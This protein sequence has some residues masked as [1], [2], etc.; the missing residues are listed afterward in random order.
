VTGDEKN[1]D[2][3]NKF[4]QPSPTE[5]A[6][7]KAVF[8]DDFDD[9]NK[10][11]LDDELP[12]D[13]PLTPELVE[14][15]AI[16]GDFMLRWAAI[17]LAI[18]MA[19]GQISDTRP[20]VLIRSGDQMRSNGFLP[21]QVDQF[22]LTMDGK[23]VTN[24]SW[25]FDH[26]VS[27]SWML[28]GEAG[29]TIL[30][31]LIAGVSAFFLVRI[32]IPG[33]SSWWSSI[34]A[35]FA[36]V[37]CSSD[38]MPTPEL[39]TVLGIT[40][41][42]RLL[43]Q[44]RLGLA[45]GLIWKLPVLIALWC[46]F[47][48]RAWVGV[49]VIAS[50]AIGSAISGKLAARKQS[51]AAAAEHRTLLV[52]AILC[53]F[54]LLANPFHINSLLSPLTTYSTEY[55]ALRAQRHLDTE[56]AKVRFD[57]RVDYYSVLNPDA[58]TLFDHSQIAGLALLLMATVVLLMSRSARDLGF[59]FALLFVTGLSVL[60]AHELSAGAVVAAVIAS[61]SAQDWYR[62]SFNTKYTVDNKELLFSRGGRAATVLALALVGFCVVAS[63]LPGTLPLGLGFD[64][65]TKITIDT[66]SQQLKDLDPQAH[67]LH[68][69]IEQGDMLI[70]NGRKSFVDSRIIPFGRRGE[71]TSVFGKHGNFL[72][73]MLLQRP[74]EEPQVTSS[75][76]KE[77]ERILAERAA[78]L[79]A[80]RETVQE[81][82]VTHV[83]SR[84]APPGKA[85]FT[86][87]RNLSATGE[88]IPVSIGPSAAILER[89]AP[90]ISQAEFNKKMINLPKLAF[91]NTDVPPT[92]LRQ[93]ATAPGFYEKYVY[94]K[95]RVTTANKR[96]GSHY[97]ELSVKEPQ[98]IAQAQAA[99]A[100]LTLSIRH[101]NQSLAEMP[102]DAE[103]FQ[104]L[105]QSYSLLGVMEQM[106]SQSGASE[107]LSQQRYLQ[108]VTAYRQALILDPSSRAAWMGLLQAYQQRNRIDLA[109]EV[110]GKWLELEDQSPQS[111][112]DEY[113]E[114]I[115][116]M[117]MQKRDYDDQI[118][119][120]DERIA[121]VAAKQNEA[122]QKQADAAR[123]AKGEAATEALKPEEAA[124]AEVTKVMV[125][126]MTANS[127]GRPR[128]AL[129]TMQENSDLVR[130][131]PLGSVLMGQILLETGD[132]E[133]AHRM[134][135][136]VSQE[137]MKQPEMMSGVDWQL[138][139]TVSQ[140]GIGDYASAVDT[141]SSQLAFMNKQAVSPT[142]YSGALYS[143]PMVADVNM[144]INE[145]L[146]VW[147][148]RNSMLTSET[149]QN[150][151]E[152]RAEAALLLAMT[153]LE[154][155]DLAE[156]KKIL[157]RIISEY[158]ETRA[159]G[160]ATFY[161]VMIDENASVMLSEN[162]TTTWE[163]F[164]YPGEK[165]PVPAGKANE[166][167][168]KPPLGL[169]PP[170]TPAQPNDGSPGAP[171]QQ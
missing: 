27:L 71:K 163:E 103:A 122:I 70:W 112:G 16:R 2:E 158:G 154:E 118:T 91:Q 111:S 97:L 8:S 147:P 57:G 100:S 101:F 105:A 93:F 25:L 48:S 144:A 88:W 59:L 150:V 84:L 119:Q 64:K 19:F 130:A 21:S 125:A 108:A 80:A 23:P 124:D 99:L 117:Y 13:E 110:L 160:L 82:G 67:V 30:K 44:H 92:T 58:I 75:D 14:E 63:R 65:E 171:P 1:N 83:M 32:S 152:G 33:I 79:A 77:K 17:F 29:L 167:S 164:E 90:T 38:F 168:T 137:A 143:L 89:V 60:A 47:D 135:A 153:K 148:V 85:D 141:W 11:E 49:G 4:E 76:P 12:E 9:P 73:T 69:L 140:L 74:G 131:N 86:S 169:S 28:G 96:Q 120:S 31:V 129:Q 68:T 41:T 126:A 45:Q 55:P 127:A 94:R 156:G 20:L 155:G 106:L 22:S 146:P 123:A 161:F 42:M 170:G 113:E 50:Y 10:K 62:R 15:E 3:L 81:F 87:V 162:R 95:R 54:A 133:E 157:T 26:L 6:V 46:N 104:L 35:V 116:Q 142:L 51:L 165:Q 128:K 5:T 136:I 34:C 132:L 115:T 53:V 18:L 145:A 121:E 52:P 24:V 7:P 151:N 159:R 56:A 72:D 43:A 107:R 61:I 78:N 98:S 114:F 66:F 39:I 134:L 138:F 102:D 37:A 40:I 109:S 139:T 36:I 166:S 149:I